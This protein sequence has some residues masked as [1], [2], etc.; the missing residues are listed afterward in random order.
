MMPNRPYQSNKDDDEDNYDWIGINI[1]D[2]ILPSS[3]GNRPHPSGGKPLFDDT[4]PR[5]RFTVSEVDPRI[6]FALVCGAKVPLR[7]FLS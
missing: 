4:D 1:K 6:H 3:L 5:L 7:T 2:L